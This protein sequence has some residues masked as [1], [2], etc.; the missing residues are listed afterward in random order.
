MLKNKLLKKMTNNECIRMEKRYCE[1]CGKALC[2]IGN[3]RKNGKS[4]NGNYSNDWSNRKYHKSCY[5]KIGES[6][7]MI[8]MCNEGQDLKEAL[9]KYYSWLDK[10]KESFENKRNEKKK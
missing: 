7:D 2:T 1:Y 5:K 3:Q 6:K 9:S 10:R 8:Y 4:F